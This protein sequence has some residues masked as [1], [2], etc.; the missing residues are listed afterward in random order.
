MIDARFFSVAEPLSL[1][2]IAALTGA[3]LAEGSDPAQRFSGVAPLRVA[4]A[5][6]VTF[7]ASARMQADLAE[8]Q[9]GACFITQSLAAAVM[10]PCALLI[11]SDPQAAFVTLGRAMY[12]DAVALGYIHPRA[13][14]APDAVI[15]A[16]CDIAAGVVIGAGAMIGAGCQI[17]AN[18]VIG[19]GVV[20]GDACTIA[21]NV[22]LSHALIGARVVIHPG[23]VIGR[24][25]FG[26][27]PGPAGLVR[28]PQLGRV[29]L[30]DDVEIGA[31]T[32]VD[33]GTGEDTVIGRG[34]KIDNL[35]Q[36]G[37]NCKI[38][39]H[40]ILVAQVGLS[41]SVTLGDGVVLAGQVGVADHV[42]IGAGARLAARSG[43]SRDVPAGATFGGAPAQEVGRW[44]REIVTLRNLSRAD[45][46]GTA[47]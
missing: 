18:T 9:A 13:E 44:R 12:P 10:R 40:C 6:D 45:K 36:I 47:L 22:S 41:G 35:V 30:E 27:V 42:T 5:Q 29:I 2:Q 33:R 23:A 14:I 4:T 34:T 37:H 46:G 43:V 32:T 7:L 3:V 31:N 8:S 19:A 21:P 39:R 28:V 25:G 20:L 16:G 17:G 26:F 24:A 11:C 1:A 38:G 15:G